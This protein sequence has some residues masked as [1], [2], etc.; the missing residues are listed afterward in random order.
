MTPSDGGAEGTAPPP[1]EPVPGATGAVP[2]ATPGPAAATPGATAQSLPGGTGYTPGSATPGPATAGPANPMGSFRLD[3]SRLSRND[4]IVGIGTLVFFISLFLSWYSAKIGPFTYSTSGISAHGYLYFPLILSIALVLY[5]VLKAGFAEL[6]FKL[7]V[8]HDLVLVGVAA[9]NL[10]FVI[11]GFIDSGPSG[12]GFS[13]GIF[14]A[15]IAAL[16]SVYPYAWPAIEARRANRRSTTTT[17]TPT[18]TN[19]PA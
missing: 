4:W 16:A 5:L 8:P 10:L 18:S 19:P 15:L 11:I 9:I 14:V 2:T 7:P 12:V 13:W 17:T 1:G 3:T 6:P